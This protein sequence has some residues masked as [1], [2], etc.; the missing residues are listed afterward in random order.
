MREGERNRGK[1]S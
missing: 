1:E